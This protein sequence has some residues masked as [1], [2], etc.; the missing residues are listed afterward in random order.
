MRVDHQAYRKAT[1]VASFGLLLQ[2]AVAMTLLVF[3][4]LARDTVFRFG[5]FYLFGG[6]LVWISLIVIFYQHTQ[7]RLEALEEHELAAARGGAGSVFETGRDAE[8]V[9]ARRLRLMHGWL[10]PS[11]SLLLIVYLGLGAGWMLRAMARLDDPSAVGVDFHTTPHRG[12]AVAV[13]LFSA[14]LCFIF[15]R[16]VAGMARQEAWQNL[17]GGAGYMVGNALILLAAAIGIVFRFFDPESTRAMEVIAYVIPAFML[18]LVAETVIHFILNIYQPRIPGHVPRPAFDSRVLSLLAAPESIVRSLN[19]AVNYQFGFDITGSW[20]YKL[21]IRSFGWLVAFGVLVLVGLNMLVVIEPHQQAIKLGGG[22]IVGDVHESGMMLKMPWPLQT[23]AVYDVGTIRV[24][25]LTARLTGDDEAQLW[26]QDLQTVTTLDPFIV[27]GAADLDDEAPEGEGPGEAAASASEHFS[28]VDSVISIQY[29]IKPG[30]LEDY[31]SFSS[32]ESRRRQRLT[33]RQSALKALALRTV[34]QH[35][36]TVPLDRTIASGRTA[37]IAELR[38]RIQAAYDEVGAG[39]E[40]VGVT[41]PVLRPA[42]NVAKF[43]EDYA[44][45][46]E[47]RRMFAAEA[48]EQVVQSLAFWIGDPDSADAILE[49]IDAWEALRAQHGPEAREVIDQRNA[50]ERMIMESGGALAQELAAAEADRWIRLMQKRADAHKLRGKEAAF[51]AA[52]E[53][54]MEREIMRVLAR[55]LARQRKYVLVGIDLDRIDLVL[56]LQ[57]GPAQFEFSDSQPQQGSQQ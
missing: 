23:A 46:R 12:W 41:V 47:E 11:V 27:G 7:E 44:M 1:R 26:A 28:L 32:D 29:R 52:P 2:F 13:C 4:Q 3:G 35:L 36:S 9:A 30:Q 31:L 6:L 5:A 54:F 33:I 42:G 16:F 56:E 48:E 53:L 49:G 15:S 34:T 55:A 37:L 22:R 18:L 40:V 21:L 38:R 50:V 43:Y 39:V 8:R 45:A 20:G 17:R 25:H 19:E 57:E 10:M 14:G 51:R 24:L